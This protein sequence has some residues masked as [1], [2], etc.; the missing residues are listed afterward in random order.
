MNV[1]EQ[2]PI[3]IHG[4]ATV[5]NFAKTLKIRRREES[6]LQEGT[7]KNKSVPTHV[8]LRFAIFSSSFSLSGFCADTG[9]K[10]IFTMFASWG[11]GLVVVCG[12]VQ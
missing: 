5:Q 9:F 8:S 6:E 7:N 2:A 10:E 11:L 12:L 3:N 4:T 1:I